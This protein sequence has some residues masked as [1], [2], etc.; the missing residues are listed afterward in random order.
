MNDKEAPLE[1][2]TA[3]ATDAAVL[4]ALEAANEL[5]TLNSVLGTLRPQDKLEYPKYRRALW[6]LVTLI[7]AQCQRVEEALNK[8]DPTYALIDPTC[9]TG[10]T[11]DQAPRRPL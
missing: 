6:M 3:K 8:L 5:T 10:E 11:P 2:A 9:A 1:P 4:N 7:Q